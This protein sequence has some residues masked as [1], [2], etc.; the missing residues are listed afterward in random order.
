M[1]LARLSCLSLPRLGR[2]FE[3]WTVEG[4]SRRPGPCTRSGNLADPGP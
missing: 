1:F 2:M 3:S 4:D